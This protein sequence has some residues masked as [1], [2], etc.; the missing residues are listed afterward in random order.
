MRSPTANSPHESLWARSWLRYLGPWPIRPIPTAILLVA[1]NQYAVQRSAQAEGSPVGQAWIQALPVSVAQSLVLF[2]VLWVALRLQRRW[3]PR[4]HR[5]V[6][7][8]A[9]LAGAAVVFSAV[10]SLWLRPDPLRA[11]T[12]TLRDFI[13]FSIITAI[14]GVVGDRVARQ[15]DRAE[16]ALEEVE[17]QR[18]QILIADERARREVADYLHDSVQADL[19][20]LAIQLEKLAERMPPTHAEQVRSVIEELENVRLLDVRTASRRLSPDIATLGLA[21]ALHEAAQGYSP[22][23]RVTIECP[24]ALPRGPGDDQLAAYRIVEQALLNAA[25]HG[26]AATCRVTVETSPPTGLI[27]TVSNDGA[28]LPRDRAAGAGTA[29]IGAWVE[30]CGGTWSLTQ[31]DGAVTLTAHLGRGD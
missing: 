1:V 8:F 12:M 23:M 27:V 18:E 29:V 24:D 10:N 4:L 30:R 26:K 14:F 5:P 3:D 13:A 28:A 2:A 31:G 7:Y 15:R 20:V 22:T 17:K 19:V 16:R 11:V 6:A 25:V 21:G 9:S